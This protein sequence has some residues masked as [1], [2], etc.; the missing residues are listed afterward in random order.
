MSSLLTDDDEQTQQQGEDGPNAEAQWGRDS[1]ALH[2]TVF[3]P[4]I[5]RTLASVAILQVDARAP[6]EAGVGH[7]VVDVDTPAVVFVV[8]FLA[9]VPMEEGG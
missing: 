1:F 3:S 8:A 4:I 5:L 9:P 2:P 7:A 6:V